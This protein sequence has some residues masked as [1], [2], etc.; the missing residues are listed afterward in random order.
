M[1]MIQV[2]THSNWIFGE[3]RE[4]DCELSGRRQKF[5]CEEYIFK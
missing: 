2:L 4:E 5:K 3:Y 1:F